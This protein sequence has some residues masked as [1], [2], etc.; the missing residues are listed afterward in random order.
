MFG[1]VAIPSDTDTF[2]IISKLCDNKKEVQPMMVNRIFNELM[3]MAGVTNCKIEYTNFVSNKNG[4]LINV[5]SHSTKQAFTNKAERKGSKWVS[6]FLGRKAA[7]SLM[8]N[9]IFIILVSITKRYSQK[10][11]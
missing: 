9:C 2:P 6:I 8:Q 10:Q 5:P 11:K 1:N 7:K 3:A 4:C